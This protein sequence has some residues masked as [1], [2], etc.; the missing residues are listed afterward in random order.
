MRSEKL[1]HQGKTSDSSFKGAGDHDATGARNLFIASFLS[2]N[3]SAT[4]IMSPSSSTFLDAAAR[5]AR[6]HFHV[7][8]ILL[9]LV[10]LLRVQQQW[11]IRIQCQSANFIELAVAPGSCALGVL[12]RKRRKNEKITFSEVK[13]H[14]TSR[15]MGKGRNR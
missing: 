5:R 11:R 2:V 8:L 3:Q 4:C 1:A 15:K 12:P 6:T 10:H 7:D 9:P 14:K 13:D